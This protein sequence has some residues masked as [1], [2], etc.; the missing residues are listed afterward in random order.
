[1]TPISATVQLNVVPDRFELREMDVLFPLQ[2]VWLEG[3]AIAI[4]TEIAQFQVSLR[5]PLLLFPPKRIN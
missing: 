2:I 1:V 3:V 5:I 4:G